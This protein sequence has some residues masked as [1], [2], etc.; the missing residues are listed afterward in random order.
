MKT[1]IRPY[2]CQHFKWTSWNHYGQKM[3]ELACKL[4][5]GEMGS[6][7]EICEQFKLKEEYLESQTS[8]R[9]ENAYTGE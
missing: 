2:M 7:Q 6:C 1:V 3:P 8:V 4:K 9:G 5:G